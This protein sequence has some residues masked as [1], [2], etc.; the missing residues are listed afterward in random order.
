MPEAIELALLLSERLDHAHAGDVLLGLGGQLGDPLLH[1]LQRRPRAPAVAVRDQD[2]ERHRRERQRRQPRLQHEHRDAREHDRQQR[3]RDEDQPVAEEEA[4]R[5]QVD[6]RAR[7]QLPGLL[8]VEE[9]QL[10]PLQLPVEHVAQVELDAERHPPG[11]EPAR[12]AQ[13]EPRDARDR[14]SRS[15]STISAWRWWLRIASIAR[16]VRY[17]ISTV[18]AIAPNAS[19]NDDSHR[20]AGT[21]AGT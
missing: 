9:R 5:L 21:G 1:L 13:R 3:L 8:A 7:H 16:P 19:A 14:R 6:G 11:D 17:G 20:P 4:D 15:P 2:D 10:E 18:I 12:D